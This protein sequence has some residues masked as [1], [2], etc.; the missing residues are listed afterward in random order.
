MLCL[1]VGGVIIAQVEKKSQ[2]G[3]QMAIRM[4]KEW[5]LKVISNLLLVK[6][7]IN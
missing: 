2:T 7:S 5:Q 4:G 6:D 1:G 3:E